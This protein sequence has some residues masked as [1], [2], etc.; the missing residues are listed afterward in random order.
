MTRLRHR[1]PPSLR[2][3]FR[4]RKPLQAAA[5]AVIKSG[6]VRSVR[7]R[8]P[9]DRGGRPVPWYT[10]PAIAWLDRLALQG[11]RVFEWGLGNST[12]YWER[13]GCLVTSVDDSPQWHARIQRQS[14]A[15]CLLATDQA[16]YVTA[17]G[18]GPYDIVCIDGSWRDECAA[19]GPS[20]LEEGGL[21]IFDNSDRHSAAMGFLR[22]AGFVQIDF[23]GLAPMNGYES[24]TSMLLRAPFALRHPGL[25]PATY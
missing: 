10:Y 21:V 24:T 19:H 2:D 25:P 6:N 23:V 13:R 20:L 7:Q 18:Q 8:E 15:T 12:L 22:D 4:W 17:P 9:V 14:T 3:A 1:L 5:V 11:A 16:S